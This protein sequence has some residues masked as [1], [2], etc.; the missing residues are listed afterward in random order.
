MLKC[1]SD[2]L[3]KFKVLKVFVKNELEKVKILR[4]DN[5]GEYVLK[6]LRLL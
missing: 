2:V 4:L 6:H 1:N 3:E 5:G